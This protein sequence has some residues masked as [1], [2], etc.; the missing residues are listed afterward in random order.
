MKTSAITLL[1]GPVLINLIDSPGHVDF[2]GEVSAALFLSDIALL[3][4]DVVEGVCSQTEFLLRKAINLNL[5]T[6]VVFNKL[7]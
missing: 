1:Y 4:I 5:D 7:D 6:I 3:V 2:S